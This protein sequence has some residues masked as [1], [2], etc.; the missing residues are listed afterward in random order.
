[1]TTASQHP[2]R[3]Q[4]F[5]FL[6]ICLLSVFILSAW[7]QSLRNEQGYGKAT[8][9]FAAIEDIDSRKQSFIDY[10]T[11][12]IVA[13]NNKILQQRT[14]LFTLQQQ[15]Q[16][17][18]RLGVEQALW[19]ERLAGRYAV[20]FDKSEMQ[21]SIRILL[22]RLNVIP[23]SLALAQ[24]ANE[25]AWGTSRF[26]IEANNYFGQWCYREGCGLVPFERSEGL[27]HEVKSFDSVADSVNSYLYTLN[28]GRAYAHLRNI[29]QQLEDEEKP[30]SGYEL[31][32][33][34][35]R[36]S[37]RGTAYVASIRSLIEANNLTAYSD[38]LYLPG[39]QDRSEI[40]F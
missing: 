20:K 35:S 3:V 16:T 22:R 5:L 1:M 13:E 19:L 25:T 12:L 6:V 11:P 36:Y 33:G 8:P 29:R 26:A 23:P 34:L 18:G 38:A 7:Y 17:E 39:D 30:L 40:A 32:A 31:A 21:A 15:L 28:S 27:S 14:Q 2:T 10:L 4:S 24:A 9:D 37:E